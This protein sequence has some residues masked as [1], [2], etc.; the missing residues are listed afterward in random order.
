MALN[1]R[2]LFSILT[3]GRFN[4]VPH[5][6]ANRANFLSADGKSLRVV[7]L[8]HAREPTLLN[9]TLDGSASILL[10]GSNPRIGAAIPSPN[11]RFLAIWEATGTS[12]VWLVKNLGS[13]D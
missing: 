3:K 13:N 2:L 10:S 11:G 7:S 5:Q 4:S 9:V 8:N 12:N 1:E 6:Q